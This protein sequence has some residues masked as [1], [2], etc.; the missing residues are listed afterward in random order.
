[1][2][3]NM[4]RDFDVVGILLGIIVGILIGYFIS[5]R[6]I[7]NDTEVG[8]TP[9]EEE[10]T[11]YIYLLQL[12]KFDNPEGALNY[13]T[14]LKKSDIYTEVVYDAS[15]YFIY[16]A[17]SNSEEGLSIKKAVIEAKGYSGLV[18]KEYILDKA[19]R[20]L[21]D[22]TKYDFWL[23]GIN[24]LIKS[25]NNEEIIIS[26]KYYLNPVDLEFFSTISILQ[27]IQNEEIKDKV[28][29]QAYRMICENLS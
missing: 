9:V 27:T 21:D 19:N 5:S 6:L 20:V 14:T 13:C 16:G 22:T 23:E 12:A 7:E 10:K 3:K 2:N 26:E 4:K 28:K 17:I 11:G 15:Y 1:M 24:N 29:L 18:K 25:L 8:G